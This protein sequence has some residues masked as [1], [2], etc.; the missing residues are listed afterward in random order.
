VRRVGNT[1]YCE[2]SVTDDFDTEGFG[3]HVLEN[4]NIDLEFSDE[5]LKAVLQ[6]LDSAADVAE[7]DRR[8]NAVFA[9]FTIGKTDDKGERI[10]W[11]YSY[12]API[13]DGHFMDEPPGDYY[14]SWGW[15]DCRGS[16]DDDLP[17][18]VK[19]VFE[20]FIDNYLQGVW[21]GDHHDTC[22]GWRIDPWRDE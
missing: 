10:N 15:E 20:T 19:N 17:E 4:D 2:V 22:Q 5:A 12:I 11:L 7:Q 16:E 3:C 18:D 21:V 13:G 9:G 14:H 8:D 1:I 6:G